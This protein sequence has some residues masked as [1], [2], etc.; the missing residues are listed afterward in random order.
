VVAS[1]ADS[2]LETEIACRNHTNHTWLCARCT[3]I[4]T[5]TIRLA[6]TNPVFLRNNTANWDAAEDR[7]YFLKWIADLIAETEASTKR[8]DTVEEK[9]EVLAIYRAARNHYLT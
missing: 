4:T 1:A 3:L 6:H 5:A 7:D 2:K 8:F 9:S